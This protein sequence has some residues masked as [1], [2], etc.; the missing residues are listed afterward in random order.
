MIFSYTRKYVS[1][2]DGILQERASRNYSDGIDK[3]NDYGSEES[4]VRLGENDGKSPEK[5]DH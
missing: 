3:P 1:E 5:P 4:K 2:I